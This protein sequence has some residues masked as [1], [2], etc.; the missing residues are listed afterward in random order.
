MTRLWL[1]IIVSMTTVS[2]E[3]MRSTGGWA[4]LNQPHC[5]VSSVAGRRCIFLPFGSGT[6]CKFGSAG[7]ICG[8]LSGRRGWRRLLLCADG[9]CGDKPSS[10]DDHASGGKCNQPSS[11]H[12]QPLCHVWN[13]CSK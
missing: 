12:G 6:V 10:A 13:I 5:V 8:S 11:L 2:P 7:P 4:L 3:L 9:G 1:C